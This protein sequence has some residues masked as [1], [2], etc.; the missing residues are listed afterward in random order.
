[1]YTILNLSTSLVYISKWIQEYK[2]YE[3]IK[4]ILMRCEV[5]TMMFTKEEDDDIS[6]FIWS[7]ASPNKMNIKHVIMLFW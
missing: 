7:V 2:K 4:I 1:M 6:Q 3:Q 5:I